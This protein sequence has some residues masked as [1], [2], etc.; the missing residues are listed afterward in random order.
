MSVSL[1]RHRAQV[2]AYTDAGAN[3]ETAPA[4]VRSV[5]GASD[6]AWWASKALPT[7]KEVTTGMQADHRVDAV[8]TFSSACPVAVDSLVVLGSDQYLVRA[9]LPRDHGRDTQ[10]VYAERA[11]D[12][13]FTLDTGA[14]MVLAR[15]V[16]STTAAAGASPAL[17]YV[18]VTEAGGTLAAPSVSDNAAW[19]S[20]SITGGVA[21]WVV[22][23]TV[24]GSALAAGTYTG[25]VTVTSAGANNTPQTITVEHTAT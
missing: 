4:Y 5:S 2:Y 17:E 25:T 24:D 22:T 13:G 6:G 14:T 20:A 11:E 19:L 8:L 18:A 15:T 23:I 3:G 9:V 12:G 10:Q 7:G 16:V 1:R 21:P